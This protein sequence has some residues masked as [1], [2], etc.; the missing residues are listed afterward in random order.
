[1]PPLADGNNDDYDNGEEVDGKGETPE[2][3]ATILH[4]IFR[5]FCRPPPLIGWALSAL[6]RGSN[7]LTGNVM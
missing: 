6:G 2:E 5:D 3:H 7:A 4:C 1:M